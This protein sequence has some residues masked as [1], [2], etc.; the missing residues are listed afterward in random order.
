MARRTA[1]YCS[2]AGRPRPNRDAKKPGFHRSP[3][4]DWFVEVALDVPWA[5]DPRIRAPITLG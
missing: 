5:K 3:V 1:T 2:H 4:G